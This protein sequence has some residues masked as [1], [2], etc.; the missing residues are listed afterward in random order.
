MAKQRLVVVGNGMA[1]ARAVEEVLARGGADKFEITM[2][3]DE[4]YGNYNR[5]MLSN[6]LSGQQNYDE[7]YLNSLDWYKEN[8]ITL[9]AG[10]RVD[11]IDRFAKV[12]TAHNG[13][14]E[15]YDTLLIATGSRSFMP[16]IPGLHQ[17]DKSLTP[18]RLRFPHHRRHQRHARR[19]RIGQEGGR[20]RRRPARARGRPRTA[21]PRLRRHR[22]PPRRTLDGAAGRRHR[23]PHAAHRDG[24]DG[25]QGPG[26]DLHRPGPRRRPGRGPHFQGR[27]RESTATCWSS[28]P[29]SA[30]TPR[31]APAPGSRCSARSWSTTT[32]AR[33][34]T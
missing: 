4:P 17:A 5:I 31:S 24:E 26:R 23:R 29:A 33:S 9:H 21:H 27:Q 22:R 8:G 19:R 3:G 7:I 15:H 2:F 12:V 13:I 1:G 25:R 32:C 20:H 11:E 10:A 30:P 6:I 18:G 14:K 16:P 34:T 28:P